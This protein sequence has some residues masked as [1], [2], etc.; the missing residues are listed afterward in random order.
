M[1]YALRYALVLCMALVGMIKQGR[2]SG[3]SYSNVGGGGSGLATSVYSL[4]SSSARMSWLLCVIDTWD[5]MR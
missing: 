1:C 5:G 4:S 2:S 3:K